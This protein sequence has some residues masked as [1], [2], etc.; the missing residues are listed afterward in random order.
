MRLTVGERLGPYEIR[1]LIG[2]GGMGEVYCAH[3]TRLGRDVAIKVSAEQFSERFEREARAV[4]ALNHPNICQLYDVGPNYLVMELVEG[5]SPRGVLPL[6]DA[7][8]IARQIADALEA[9]HEKGIVHRDLKPGNIKIKPDGV[10]KVLDF[11]L[12]KIADENTGKNARATDSPT[13]TM[14]GVIMGTAAYM[15]PE[16]A[17]GLPIDKRADIWAFGAVL[18][19]MLT[20][21][22]L[23]GGQTIT[24][25]LAAVVT[26][27]P[28]WERVPR[29][30]RRLLRECL[31]RDPRQRL[32]DIG[33]AWALL[34]P[35]GA[36]AL[37]KPEARLRHV[38]YALAA[39]AA[40]ALLC[41]AAVS[42]VHFREAQPQPELVRFQIPAPENVSQGPYLAQVSPDGKKVA[43]PVG[44]PGASRLWI[45]TLDSVEMRPLP[46]TEG[47]TGTPIW[48]FDSRSIAFSAGGALKRVDV[49][50][51]PPLKICD[52]PA[53][54]GFWTRDGTIVIG[55]GSDLGVGRVPAA[56]GAVTPL[57]VLDH[58][59]GEDRHLVPVPLPD[60]RHFLYLRYSTVVENSGIYAGSLDAKPQEQSLHRILATPYGAQ[61]VPSADPRHG[62]LLFFRDGTVFAQ[63]FDTQRLELTGEPAP[64]ADRVGSFFNGGY[65]SASQNGVLIYWGEREKSLQLTWF[66]RQ[67]RPGSALGEP[68]DYATMV[69]SPEGTRVATAKADLNP[70]IW[71]IETSRGTST[72]FTAGTASHSY[73]VWAPDGN[74]IAYL[75]FRGGRYGVYRKAANGAGS[76]QLLFE[77]AEPKFPTDWSRDGRFLLFTVLDP[78]TKYDIWAL[79]MEGDHKPFSVL[80]TQFSE[81]NGS[82][83]PDSQSL[84]Y[85]SNASGRTEVYIQPF[86][87]PSGADSSAGGG[88][89]RVSTNG[90]SRPRWRRD[91]KE[92]LYMAPDGKMMSVEMNAGKPGL[93][94]PLF[95][96]PPGFTAWDVSSDGTQFLFAVPH[97]SSTR[98]EFTVV[99][100]WQAGL[101]KPVGF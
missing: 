7:L 25:V 76:E 40:V 5:E 44:S 37:R 50:A 13:L 99:L 67:G 90:G 65:F 95:Q 36:E 82:F 4:A 87:P 89:V 42:L 70:D 54:G 98:P 1:A 101:R 27:N 35:D 73:P 48:S 83:S 23:F 49:A 55:A 53:L 69:L 10:V 14:A 78:K 12:A 19:E 6:E 97:T 86:A 41:A 20:G 29:Q 24:D 62:F 88:A 31:Q 84:T 93:A 64:V 96:A 57:T 74:Q 17:R 56:G 2:A 80:N 66:D 59:R 58:S 3:D 71:L 21:E 81:I 43:F 28:D 68:G 45:R 26:K 18:W 72:R 91:G 15:S 94:K 100:N 32:R 60:G 8:R 79:P 39:V 38:A 52:C 33:D 22:Q 85:S 30:V 51:G 63:P 16:Q 77:S 47:F 61:F 34:E 75:S 92:L 11:G 46:G 9:A